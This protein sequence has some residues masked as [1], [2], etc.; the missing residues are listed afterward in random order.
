ML[1]IFVD[2]LAA[3]EFDH[4]FSARAR[5]PGQIR[6][7]TL[8]PVQRVVRLRIEVVHVDESV[9]EC[10]EE[11]RPPTMLVAQINGT[12]WQRA[13]I[14]GHGI[15]DGVLTTSR[16]EVGDVTADA[17]ST[18]RRELY[19]IRVVPAWNE[20]SAKRPPEPGRR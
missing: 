16:A 7:R 12:D 15:V 20:H 3:E 14:V 9:R 1:A 8:R 17:P 13:Q 11:R 10:R 4:Q 2:A 5:I 18:V 6:R 19:P